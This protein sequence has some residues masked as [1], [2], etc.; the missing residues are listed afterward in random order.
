MT[1][2]AARAHRLA[3]SHLEPVTRPATRRVA[4]Y[5]RVSTDEQAAL[6][7]NSL[8]AQEQICKAY[9]SMRSDDPASQVKWV[10]AETYSDPGYSG[11]T[12]ERPA[13]KRLLVDVEA[14][15]IEVIAC[16]KIDR[17][18]R[19]IHQFYRIWELMERHGIDLVSATQDLNTSTSQ[20]KL[21]L[22]M[23]LSFGQYE[24]ELVGE[25]TRDKIAAARRR[26]LM[27]GG[28]QVLGYD[29][30][31]GRLVVN[32]E[33]ACRVRE[34]FEIYLRERSLTATVRELNLKSIGTKTWTT[35]DGRRREGRPMD[36]IVLYH[37]LRRPLYAGKVP[38][39]GTLYPGQHDAIVGEEVWKR[40]Q[41][42]LRR[43]GSAGHQGPRERDDSLLKGLLR[44]V[45]CD[46]SMSPTY[47]EKGNRRYRYYVCQSILK[48]GSHSCPTGR[49][50]AHEIE[51]RVVEQIRA[52]GRDPDLL[53]ETARQARLQRD[54]MVARLG[55]ENRELRRELRGK[56]ATLARYRAS[57]VNSGKLG[58]VAASKLPAVEERITV[59]E[60]R[61]K[62]VFSELEGAR[63]LDVSEQ[64]IRYA[65]EAFGPV[66]ESLWPAER[67]RILGLLV[68]RVDYDGRDEGLAIRFR[69]GDAGALAPAQPT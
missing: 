23:L 37:L 38:H 41:V 50:P 22:N 53:A 10:H 30:V 17:L 60:A 9:V 31:S 2:V 14:G 24:R 19:S 13:L 15:K 28:M 44:C 68:D 27:A 11:G 40:A 20:G 21:M 3:E 36:K 49:V 32:E 12:L 8:Q 16:Y 45:G 58:H 51:A 4:I 47:T 35:K 59:I 5:T 1:P 52:I 57:A 18:S 61:L 63:R 42:L 54:E 6:E 7:F 43:N 34:I 64:G 66:W 67:A 29:Q 39:K 26:G 56:K 62:A 55:A 33:E 48:F 25:R 46:C 65:L 69:S